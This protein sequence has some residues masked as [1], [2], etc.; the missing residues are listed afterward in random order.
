MT[1]AYLRNRCYNPRTGKISYEYLTCTK[2]NLSN[3]H[4]FG[5]VRYAYIQ[6]KTKL[7]PRAEKGIFVGYD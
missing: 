1:S 6:N 5:T 4:I 7:D 2:L 3:M